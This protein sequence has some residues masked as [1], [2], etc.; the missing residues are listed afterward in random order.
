LLPTLRLHYGT[1]KY[2]TGKLKPKGVKLH[3]SLP[4]PGKGAPYYCVAAVL[5]HQKRYL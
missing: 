4:A 5:F 2:L 3:E 1:A